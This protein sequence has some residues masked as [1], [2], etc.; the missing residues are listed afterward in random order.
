[1]R[2]VTFALLLRYFLNMS[3]AWLFLIQE[4]VII[5]NVKP[6]HTKSIMNKP[7]AQGRRPENVERAGA[8]GC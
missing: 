8:G 3:R 1:M 7:Q 5:A 4:V 2:Y 6:F